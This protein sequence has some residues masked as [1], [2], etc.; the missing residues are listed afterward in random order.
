MCY[1]IG[2]YLVVAGWVY[3][4]SYEATADE[5]KEEVRKHWPKYF[6]Q[7]LAWPFNLVHSG[8]GFKRR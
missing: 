5:F 8:K 2:F 6:C 1:I 4:I 3:I 7:C